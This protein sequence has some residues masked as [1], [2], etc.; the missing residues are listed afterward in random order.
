MQELKEIL[1]FGDEYFRT[2]EGEVESSKSALQGYTSVLNS[3]Q[4]E[5]NLANFAR[6][7]PRH[8]RFKYRHPWKQYLKIGS[9]SRQ[10]AYRIDALHG[11]LNT[12]SKTP[13]EIR[14]KF[15]EPC[16]KMSKET[17]NALKE[18]AEAISKMVVPSCA[19]PHISKSKMGAMNLRSKLTTELKEG[20]NILE[21]IPA[22]TVAWLLVDV[23]SCT[24]KL[25]E[26][27][28][29]LSSQAKFKNKEV[30]V[31]PEESQELPNTT[32]N[33]VIITVN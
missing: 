32:P 30:K 22:V 28:Q 9:L 20:A 14:S 10:C 21:A 29:E 27:I 3:K 31:A 24:E 15:E 6:W 2:S 23:V 19:E 11:F 18:L 12:S 13:V 4:A 25:A 1:R 26:S 8:G 5:E 16:M 17:G 33:H 7:E